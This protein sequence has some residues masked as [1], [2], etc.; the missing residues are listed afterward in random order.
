MMSIEQVKMTTAGS[1]NELRGAAVGKPKMFYH[2]IRKKCRI[3]SHQQDT[4]AT[5]AGQK[6]AVQ[7][8]SILILQENVLVVVRWKKTTK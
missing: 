5:C 1:I 7:L 3:S 6:C 4:E 8:V 2:F